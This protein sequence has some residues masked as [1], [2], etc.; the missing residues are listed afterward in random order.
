MVGI[1]GARAVDAHDVGRLGLGVGQAL[2]TGQLVNAGHGGDTTDRN[3]HR[4]R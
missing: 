3:G 1:H 4:R 2:P